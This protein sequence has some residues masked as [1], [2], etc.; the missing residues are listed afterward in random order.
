M[1]VETFEALLSGV[2]QGYRQDFKIW[3]MYTTAQLFSVEEIQATL[4]ILDIILTN[5]KHPQISH[6]LMLRAYMFRKGLGGERDYTAAITLYERAINNF[7]N[8]DAMVGRARM[9]FKA[10]GGKQDAAAAISLYQRAFALGNAEA[11]IALERMDV[12]ALGTDPCY[13]L[14]LSR[15]IKLAAFEEA[16]LKILAGSKF[17]LFSEVEAKSD[18]SE[19]TGKRMRYSI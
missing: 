5:R 10:L 15:A 4:K 8:S 1:K 18:L 17:R 16:D 12:K 6:A 7:R 14:A 19:D 13:T 9:H 11:K 2:L 3:R